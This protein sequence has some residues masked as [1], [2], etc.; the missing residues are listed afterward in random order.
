[1]GLKQLFQ[2]LDRFHFGVGTSIESDHKS[3]EEK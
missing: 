2:G 1:M 3:K